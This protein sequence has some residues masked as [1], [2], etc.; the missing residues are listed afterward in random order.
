MEW[1]LKKINDNICI[2][3]I[4][5]TAEAKIVLFERKAYG[6]MII[7]LNYFIWGGVDVYKNIFMFRIIID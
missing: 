7:P 4:K 5:P 6:C 2:V 3:C 1:S